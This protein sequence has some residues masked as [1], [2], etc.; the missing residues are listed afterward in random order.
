[1]GALRTAHTLAWSA[2]LCEGG[3]TCH[4]LLD[5]QG[6]RWGWIVNAAAIRWDAHLGS[7]GQADALGLVEPPVGQAIAS[8]AELS[9]AK[10]WVEAGVASAWRREC[11]S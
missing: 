11:R 1:M 9:K 2:R 4:E 8:W 7:W 3:F 5:E 6:R 10:E